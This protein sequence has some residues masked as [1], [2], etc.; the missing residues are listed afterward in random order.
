MQSIDAFVVCSF[1]NKY[2]GYS[3]VKYC[4]PLVSE[5]TNWFVKPA[6]Q[7]CISFVVGEIFFNK[8]QEN[9]SCLKCLHMISEIVVTD[10]DLPKQVSI[11]MF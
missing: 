3:E 7:S 5:T 9:K 11:Q 10:D 1:E 6:F 2:L 4:T 8:D